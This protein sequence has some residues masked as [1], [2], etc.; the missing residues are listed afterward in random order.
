VYEQAQGGQLTLEAPSKEGGSSENFGAPRGTGIPLPQG[1]GGSCETS[2]TLSSAGNLSQLG[3][4]VS[5]D[6]RRFAASRKPPP[7]R[8]GAQKDRVI[9]QPYPEP[10]PDTLGDM[11]PFIDTPS[12]IGGGTLDTSGA[13]QETEISQKNSGASRD[14]GIFQKNSGAT[15]NTESSFWEEGVSSNIFEVAQSAD[16]GP[17]HG[18]RAAWQAQGVILDPNEPPQEEGGV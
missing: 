16:Q 6:L 13:T 8:R 3:G 9:T 10:Y 15:P 4:G 7:S 1:G 14:I 11:L 5:A 17:S 18:G 12:C 2:N